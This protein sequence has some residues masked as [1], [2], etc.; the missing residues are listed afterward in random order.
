MKLA[1]AALITL[2]SALALG[3]CGSQ[4]EAPPPPAA[5]G[6]LAPGAVAR[7]GRHV[8]T[9]PL[10]AHVAQAQRVPLP[11]AR[12]RAVRDALLASEADRRGH[13]GALLG[14][15]RG[16]GP[17][18]QLVELRQRGEPGQAR[19]RRVVGDE[20][21]PDVDEPAQARERVE[22]RER[23][24]VRQRER[25]RWRAA[26][27]ARAAGGCAPTDGPPGRRPPCRA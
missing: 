11:E 19:E 13:G 2:A 27:S 25:D 23:E 24:R 10:V 3:G 16:Q 6:E 17:Q 1:R 22:R 21:G 9:V 18:D 20:Q 15:E 14:P 26:R 5:S 12:D 7:V 8:V 4:K